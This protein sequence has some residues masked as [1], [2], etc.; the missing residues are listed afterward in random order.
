MNASARGRSCVRPDPARLERRG[1]LWMLTS[2]AICPCH[3]PVTLGVLFT[4][5]GG[6]AAGVWLREHVVFA[7]VV[8]GLTWAAGTAWGAVLVRRAS[9]LA[10]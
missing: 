6:T 7:S 8:I 2:F 10:Q 9:Q 4:L 1:R 5:L 3:L